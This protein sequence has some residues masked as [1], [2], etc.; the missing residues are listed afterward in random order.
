MIIILL[1]LVSE[2][3]LLTNAFVSVT[4]PIWKTRILQS[5]VKPLRSSYVSSLDVASQP[6][7]NDNNELKQHWWPA[8]AVSQLDSSRPNEV[9]VM[10]ES[11]CLWKSDY[12]WVCFMNGGAH[13]MEPLSEGRIVHGNT[14]NSLCLESSLDGWQYDKNGF[15]QYIPSVQGGTTGISSCSVTNYPLKEVAGI[16]WIYMEPEAGGSEQKT[17]PLSKTFL[18]WNDYVVSREQF[19]LNDIIVQELPYGFGYLGESLLNLYELRDL[20]IS[21]ASAGDG[22]PLFQGPLQDASSASMSFYPPNHIRYEFD[23]QEYHFFLCVRTSSTSSC[24]GVVIEKDF[25]PSQPPT[26]ESHYDILMN[27]WKLPLSS[28]KRFNMSGREYNSKTWQDVAVSAFRRYVAAYG[29]PTESLSPAV[30]SSF[31]E[32]H[33]KHCPVC[34]AAWDRSKR[35]TNRLSIVETALTGAA[36][37]STLSLLLLFLVGSEVAIPMTF[38][39]I[40]FGATVASDLGVVAVHKFRNSMMASS[41]ESNDHLH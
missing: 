31:Y 5:N 12:T 21:P 30:P 3:G 13:R 10:G 15:C 24:L 23:T 20:S 4:L 19:K 37:A 32:S 2:I 41:N 7:N 18:D 22:S 1:F 40:V 29:L 27:Q 33:V 6:T 17:L 16:L 26:L 35:W 11:L 14:D 36:G 38:L 9:Y 28:S 25:L 8:A 34:L 39:R